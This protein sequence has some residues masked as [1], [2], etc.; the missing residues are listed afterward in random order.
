ML[1]AGAIL[2]IG[3]GGGGNNGGMIEYVD[4][5][6][7]LGADSPDGYERAAS[8][9][10]TTMDE[11]GVLRSLILPPPRPAGAYIADDYRQL[12]V[13]ANAHPDRFGFLAGGA[14]LNPLI[15]R[16]VAAGRVTDEDRQLFTANADAIAAAGAVGYGEMTA[17]HLSLGPVHPYESA[18]PDHPLF[19]LL[20]DI[21]ASK[22]MPIDL[23]MEAVPGES[24]P[25]PSDKNT[26]RG[27][28]NPDTLN[29]NIDAFNRLLA[30]NRQTKIIWDHI[31]WDHTGYRTPEATR[32]MLGE[33]P[34]L[35]M[36]IK[37][38]PDS[39]EQNQ[40]M[41]NGTIKLEWLEV[42]EQFP[43]R[44]ILGSDMFYVPPGARAVGPGGPGG[45]R[46]ILNQLPAELARRFAY[47]N[48][49]AIFG[50]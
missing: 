35:Y 15:Q 20:S 19:L 29:G 33:N 24:I 9:A 25:L 48:A 41:Q 46:T 49:E 30:H 39:P 42:F 27:V 40:I 43:D 36:S 10:L 37:D 14:S 26:A 5:H 17:E 13:V 2:S 22:G 28:G 8:T 21:A 44:F 6:T 38:H 31:G 1:L 7:H 50:L 34:N 12:S 23:H 11:L 16:A 45:P 4:T 32:Q 47:E 18:P 3:C